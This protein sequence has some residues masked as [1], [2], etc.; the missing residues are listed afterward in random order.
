MKK[1]IL[2]VNEY[3]ISDKFQE[4]YE[5]LISAANDRGCELEK[6]TNLE[7]LAED[8][9]MADFVLF[10]DKDVKAAKLLE[11]KGFKVFNCAK[12]IE[13]CD[14]KSLTYL[15]LIGSGINMPKTYVSPLT[16]GLESDDD[17]F[18]S[19]V[20]GKVGLPM[21]IKEN[22]GSFGAQVYLA[23]TLDKAKEIVLSFAGKGYIVQEFIESS[24]GR[25]VRLHIVGD[26]F[27]TAMLRENDNDF[28]ANITNG[29]VMKQ[30][31]PTEL[32]IEMAVKVCKE[33]NLDF[34]GVDIMFGRNG[35]PIFCEVNSNAHFKNIMDCT[36]VNVAESIMDYILERC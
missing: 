2:V 19:K 34:A 7:V 20:V 25:D 22:F 31:D 4:I 18:L 35:E 33:L 13:V 24:T 30:Y 28:R 6:V 23:E 5:Y 15:E 16:F 29:G 21:V 26:K 9:P 14:D 8:I 36:G 27:V 10:W 3:L 17:N 32:Q 11:S 12:A 1:G